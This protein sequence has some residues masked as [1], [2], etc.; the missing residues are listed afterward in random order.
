MDTGELQIQNTHTWHSVILCGMI[1]SIFGI[2][3]QEI[4]NIYTVPF[5]IPVQTLRPPIFLLYPGDDMS[6]LE[7]LLSTPVA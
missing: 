4:I 2:I 6:Y 5:P 7:L 1:D 3:I